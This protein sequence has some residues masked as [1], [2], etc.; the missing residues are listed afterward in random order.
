[1]M[2][3]AAWTIPAADEHCSRRLFYF[4]GSNADVC[5]QTVTAGHAGKFVAGQNIQLR[6]SPA[7]NEFLLL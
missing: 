4:D 2:P 6:N 5:G 3:G 1:M 7:E